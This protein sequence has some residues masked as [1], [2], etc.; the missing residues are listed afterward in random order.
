[1]NKNKKLLIIILILLLLV[2]AALLLYVGRD[3][4]TF[5]REWTDFAT[6]DTGSVSMLFLADKQNRAVKI[7]RDTSGQWVL[8]DS[9]P[10]SPMM[11]NQ[12]LGTIQRLAVRYPVPKSGHN[13]VIGRIAAIGV[14][15][16]I[17]QKKPLIHIAGLKLFTRERKTRTYYVGDN[18]MDNMGTYFLMEGA[19]RPFVVYLPGFRGFISGRFTTRAED[20]RDHRIFSSKLF[21]ISEVSVDFP[22]DGRPSYKV[23]NLNDRNFSITLKDGT[24]P[25]FPVDTLRLLN[26]LASFDNIRFEAFLTGRDSTYLD[27]VKATVPLHV[28]TVTDRSGRQTL[29]TT[30]LRPLAEPDTD[31]EGKPVFHDRDRMYAMVNGG[32]DFVLVQYFVFNRITR[33]LG[34]FALSGEN[35]QQ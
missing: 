22:A 25:P 24:A 28:I 2:V 14:K 11:V 4:G 3:K 9:M 35:M 6:P 12:L 23:T 7:S 5:S 29:A 32:K 20:W 10:A 26:F 15:V 30:F 27:S 16:E 19:G 1:M 21:E 34:W 18:T 17:Y 13:S 31:M 33:D 8:N